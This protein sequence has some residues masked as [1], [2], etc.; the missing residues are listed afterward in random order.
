MGDKK[1]KKNSSGSNDAFKAK[2]AKSQAAKFI[3]MPADDKGK[4]KKK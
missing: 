3:A 2:A 1:P 4:A